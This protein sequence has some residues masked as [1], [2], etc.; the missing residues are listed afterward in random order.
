MTTASSRGTVPSWGERGADAI[1]VVTF[2]VRPSHEQLRT[3]VRAV[4]TPLVLIARESGDPLDI[5]AFAGSLAERFASQYGLACV[6]IRAQSAL[7][8]DVQPAEPAQVAPDALALRVDW[9]MAAPEMLAPRTTSPMFDVVD[10]LSSSG[11]GVERVSGP[12]MS[13]G[14]QL[15]VPLRSDAE[16]WEAAVDDPDDVLASPRR[17]SLDTTGARL[18][19]GTSSDC[20]VGRAALYE[21]DGDYVTHN[22]HA[23][24]PTGRALGLV[25]SVPRPGTRAIYRARTNGCCILTVDPARPGLRDSRRLGY[26][27]VAGGANRWPLACGMELLGYADPVPDAEAPPREVAFEPAGSRPTGQAVAKAR[28]RRAV[29]R[30]TRRPNVLLLLPWF[31]FG[32]GDQLM[33]EIAAMLSARRHRVTAA[34]TF[35]PSEAAPDNSAA[36]EPHVDAIH[37]LSPAMTGRE[38]APSLGML[39]RQKRIDRILVCGGWQ[40]YPALP[41]LRTAFPELTVM[42]QLFNDVGHLQSNRRWSRSIDLTV[43]AYR[44]LEDRI[45]SEWAEDRKRVCTIYV[46][47]DVERFERAREISVRDARATLGLSPG[48]KVVGAVG[49]LS[50]EK[51]FDLLVRAVARLP[52]VD[53]PKV[54]LQG[55]G[56]E[57]GALRRLAAQMDVDLHLRPHGDDVMATLRALDAFV[58]TSDIE[59]I[60]QSV[61]E[62]MVA[63]VPVVAT[64]VGG[65]PELVADGRG[66]LVAPG[67]PGAI[68]MGLQV[69]LECPEPLRSTMVSDARSFV[70]RTMDRHAML[71]A[72]ARLFAWSGVRRRS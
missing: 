45:R 23:G 24:T 70:E 67:S 46:G 21:V 65:V 42:D 25:S 16:R 1:S 53:R 48:E 18:V 40:A 5:R 41:A 43:C 26:V 58:L 59:G 14:D 19:L 56:P 63:E 50:G 71:K 68:A 28:A 60:P 66:V 52:M 36:L 39:V 27:H 69:M 54:L 3:A 4:E 61:M 7:V 64:A 9:L 57:E 20:S 29:A 31:S 8:G 11:L 2:D 72:Y 22:D 13:F 32:G 44:G 35:D 10:A 34:L 33:R 17:A 62:A 6:A 55:S 15:V 49:R 37:N 38:L 12:V 30:V 51:R 47:I